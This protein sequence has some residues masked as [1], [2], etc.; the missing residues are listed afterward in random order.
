MEKT[1]R[2]AVE[3]TENDEGEMIVKAM[4]VSEGFVPVP[5]YKEGKKDYI[6]IEEGLFD[7]INSYPV[8]GFLL[9]RRRKQWLKELSAI[10]Y[11]ENKPENRQMYDVAVDT[12]L[13]G[14]FRDVPKI[15]D[16]FW[17]NR[18]IEE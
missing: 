18:L 16:E 7:H 9:D 3:E 1:Y 4:E 14:Y 12:A 11:I 2:F 10:L 6:L 5:Y 15:E 13:N 8:E 17:Q